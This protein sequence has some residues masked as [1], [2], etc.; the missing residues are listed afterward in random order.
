M[1]EWVNWEVHI[2]VILIATQLVDIAR[3]W[4]TWAAAESS[5]IKLTAT[6]QRSC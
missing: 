4:V 2:V 3:F 5:D 6:V 1:S